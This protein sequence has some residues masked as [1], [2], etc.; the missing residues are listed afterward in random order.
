MGI[1]VL[2]AAHGDY[3]ARPGKGAGELERYFEF[4]YHQEVQEES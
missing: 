1:V 2:S 3:F 4:G